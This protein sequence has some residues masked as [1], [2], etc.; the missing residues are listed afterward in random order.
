MGKY[1]FSRHEHPIEQNEHILGN[2]PFLTQRAPHAP[3]LYHVLFFLSPSLPTSK[4]VRG[5]MGQ[6]GRHMQVRRGSGVEKEKSR[7]GAEGERKKGG[8]TC[9]HNDARMGSS[10]LVCSVLTDHLSVSCLVSKGPR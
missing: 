5:G 9:S 4:Q 1:G 7:Q 8:K 3:L 6:P 2:Q 10:P